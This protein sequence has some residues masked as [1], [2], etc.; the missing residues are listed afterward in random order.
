M[1]EIADVVH[2]ILL[3][4]QERDALRK[5]YETS[6]ERHSAQ[7][8]V[9]DGSILRP[10]NICNVKIRD[11]REY[12][13]MHGREN[14]ELWNDVRNSIRSHM[15]AARLEGEEYFKAQRP[16]KL[17][18][19]Y[20][21]V[22]EQFPALRRFRNSWA[23]EFLVKQTF[24]G[25]RSYRSAKNHQESYRSRQRRERLSRAQR[26]SSGSPAAA[27]S[28]PARETASRAV[29]PESD[30][31][32]GLEAQGHVEGMDDLAPLPEYSV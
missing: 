29:S 6:Q 2:P 13:N 19:I 1:I 30:H 7:R 28:M 10:S 12:L 25:R 23:T 8:E 4:K 16:K 3:M 5:Q 26:S 27:V 31:E 21:A 32:L 17:S 22:E 15:D 11:I 9:E 18:R 14:D 24:S 20:D